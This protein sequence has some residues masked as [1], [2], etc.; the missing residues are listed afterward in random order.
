[1]TIN[2]LVFA[3]NFKE[4]INMWRAEHGLPSD[5][6]IIGMTLIITPGDKNEQGERSQHE[7]NENDDFSWFDHKDEEGIVTPDRSEYMDPEVFRK[8]EQE[9]C[10]DDHRKEDSSRCTS[11]RGQ[12]RVVRPLVHLLRRKVFPVQPAQSTASS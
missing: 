4:E 1:M 3:R 10:I 9:G 5:S 8:K 2:D 12:T 11:S 6:T 7:N